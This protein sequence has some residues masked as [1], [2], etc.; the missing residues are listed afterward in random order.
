MQSSGPDGENR[1][2][3]DMYGLHVP[4]DSVG[5]SRLAALRHK[6]KALVLMLVVSRHVTVLAEHLN[7]WLPLWLA[8]AEMVDGK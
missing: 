7:T 3:D 5:F 2:V 8:R 6:S 4:Y 1:L